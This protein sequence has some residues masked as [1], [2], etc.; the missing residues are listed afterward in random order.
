MNDPQYGPVLERLRGEADRW[1]TEIRDTGLMPEGEMSTKNTQQPSFDYV[2]SDA[3]DFTR[4]KQAADIASL[5][6][7]S[8]LDEIIGF[9]GDPNQTVRYWGANGCLI[10]KEEAAPAKAAL[11]E[12]LDDASADVRIAAA[13]ALCHLGASDAAIPV[14][15]G[16]LD[17][18]NLMVRVHA[19]NSLEIIGGEVAVAALPKVRELVD[20]REDRAYDIRAGKRLVEMYGG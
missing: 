3:Y 5:R 1:M 20:G 12:V 17:S 19:L 6:D 13:E 8:R 2:H 11:I 15:I 14:F 10:L 7:P 9:L 16:A 4:I 18:D